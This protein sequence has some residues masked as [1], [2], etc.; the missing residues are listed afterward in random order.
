LPR[1]S[2]AADPVISLE[3][4][5]KRYRLYVRRHQ[6]LK[7]M[8]VKRSR[9]DWHDLWA[10]KDVSF[11]VPKGQVVGVIGENG[12]G[13]STLLKLLSRILSPD[14]GTLQIAGRVSSL[15]EL[16]AGFQPEYNGRENVFLYGALLGLGR[17]EVAQRFDDIV[18]FSELGDFIEHPVKNYSSGMYTR[19]GFSVAV[20]LRPEILLVD[21]VLAVGDESFQKKCYEHLG[22]LRSEGC[23]ILLVSHDL[24]AVG[25]FCE[26]AIWLDH[27]RVGADGP[28][29]NTIAGYLDVAAQRASGRRNQAVVV[30]GFGRPSG[31][32]EIESVR[33]LDVDGKPTRVLESGQKACVEIRY[34]AHEDLPSVMFNVTI[35]RSDGVRCTDAPSSEHGKPGL[36][37]ARG[38]GVALLEFP[39]FGFHSGS[40][41]ATVAIHDPLRHT[42]YA[43]HER[44]YPFAMRDPNGG[45][46]VVWIEHHWKVRQTTASPARSE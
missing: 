32:I 10:L 40:Y 28:T 33:F 9:G 46:A 14:A 24:D 11:Q 17:R 43:Y 26:R 12:S 5:S 41:D 1:R 29:E 22:K 31:E 37:I 6:S 7:E 44:L 13:K 34:L 23:T 45:S 2:D 15:L 25:R 38:T 16:G 8:L 19:L 35:F 30:P 4:V 27:G 18:A 21:E 39:S 42:L 20:H 36:R 3:G